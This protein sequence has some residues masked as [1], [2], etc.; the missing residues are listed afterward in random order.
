[1]KNFIKAC[2]VAVLVFVVAGIVL[3]IVAAAGGVTRASLR[4]FSDQ[5]RLSYGPVNI[6]MGDGFSVNIGGNYIGNNGETSSYTVT[7]DGD[8]L[9]YRHGTYSVTEQVTEL[10]VDVAAGDFVILPSEDAYFHV[11]C[12]DKIRVSYDD[13]DLKIER[14]DNDGVDLNFRKIAKATVYVPAEYRLEKMTIDVAAGNMDINTP[15]YAKKVNMEVGAGNISIN[16]PVEADVLKMEV[17]AG[18]I[19]G[20]ACITAE[21]ALEMEV[22]A[23]DISIEDMECKGSLYA[24]CN[25]GNLEAEGKVYGDIT[26]Q[27]DVGNLTMN[28]TGTGEKYNYRLE[29]SLGEVSV[30]GFDYAGIDS[31]VYLEGDPEAP[32]V[33]LS[34]GMG[35]L[36]LDIR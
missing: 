9:L 26:A 14:V 6:R 7:E 18:N 30:N 36:E 17:G 19:D 34:C 12:D 1:M 35:D 24:E 11:D 29:S 23:G 25:M 13:G 28:L 8:I 5:G 21:Q 3:L 2:L 22:N 27:C 15:L 32:M 16:A 33:K 20:Y 4:L 31:D 10:D